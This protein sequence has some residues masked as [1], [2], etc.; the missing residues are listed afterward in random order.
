M[1]FN[2][3]REGGNSYEKI[4]DIQRSLFQRSLYGS[5]NSSHA[6]MVYL[7]IHEM[8]A[9]YKVPGLLQNRHFFIYFC[10]YIILYCPK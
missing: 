7:I 9:V 2:R 3:L 4:R 6:Y 10:G 5:Q 8:I 1:V